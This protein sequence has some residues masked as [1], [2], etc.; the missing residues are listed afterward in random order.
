MIDGRN[1][2]DS[3]DISYCTQ[4]VP[5]LEPK[6]FLRFLGE[7][8]P[9]QRRINLN[10]P[11]ELNSEILINLGRLKSQA[12]AAKY[13]QLVYLYDPNQPPDKQIISREHTQILIRKSDADE[14]AVSIADTKIH[15][16]RRKP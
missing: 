8:N 13:Q 5:P 2:V 12:T 4:A 6:A 7:E 9:S 3:G 14:Y 16:R 15:N 10:L 11:T 1:T